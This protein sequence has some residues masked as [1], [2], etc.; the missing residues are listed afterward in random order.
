MAPSERIGADALVA[1]LS[2]IPALNHGN[3]KIL[4]AVR[5]AVAKAIATGQSADQLAA[6][7]NIPAAWKGIDLTK[8]P[9][10]PLG[11]GETK[12][13][14]AAKEAQSAPLPA[15]KAAP[16][17]WAKQIVPIALKDQETTRVVVLDREPTALG[18]LELPAWARAQKPAATFGPI[19]VSS[20]DLQATTEK[21]IL[22]FR[23]GGV[24]QFIRAGKVLCV[25][26]ISI[27]RFGHPTQ[28]RVTAGSAWIAVTHLRPRHRRAALRASVF[29]RAGCRLSRF[30]AVRRCFMESPLPAAV[31]SRCE[32]QPAVEPARGPRKNSHCRALFARA[33]EWKADQ[34]YGG[35]ADSIGRLGV[36]RQPDYRSDATG[37]SKRARRFR[38]SLR[39]GSTLSVDGVGQA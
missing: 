5:I 14:P 34:H 39:T 20:A 16:P 8:P 19:S 11:G 22:T 1:E 31:R 37:D 35:R 6:D 9:S 28:A 23:F 24:A 32:L 25:L 26:P 29:P 30:P 3:D 12:P 2:K 4:D 13:V 17:D 36:Q 15:P 7:L 21:W 10:I 27:L 33:A 18:G 38:A